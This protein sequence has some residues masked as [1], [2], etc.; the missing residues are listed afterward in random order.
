MM[1]RGSKQ[2]SLGEGE[3]SDKEDGCETGE[4]QCV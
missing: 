2:D 1:G 4:V 3:T